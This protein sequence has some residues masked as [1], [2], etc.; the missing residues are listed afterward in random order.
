MKKKYQ[1]PTTETISLGI[2]DVMVPPDVIMSDP[3]V[4]ANT[5][6]FDEGENEEWGSENSYQQ[7]TKLWN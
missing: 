7:K 6:V 5:S 2:M 1:I 4:G 3:T